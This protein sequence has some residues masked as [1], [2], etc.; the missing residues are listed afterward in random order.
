MR[1]IRFI[2]L[3]VLVGLGL[4]GY[5]FL[6]YYGG[7]GA[8]VGAHAKAVPTGDQEIAYIQAATS[9]ATWE[10]FVAGI[11]NVKHDW[12]G[13]IV[14]DRE[15]LSHG[16]D[17]RAGGG[18]A[19]RRAVRIVCGFA[20]TS[21][22]ATPIT[23]NGCEELGR[24]DPP[25]LA[26]IGG[27]SSDRARDLAE[28]L[29]QQTTWH[30]KPPLLML[31]TATADVLYVGPQHNQ[32]VPL[33]DI[34]P[35]RTF[36]FCFT[37]RPDGRGGARTGLVSSVPAAGRL[38]GSR[39]AGPGHRSAPICGPAWA[40][41]RRRRCR[42]PTVRVLEWEDDP[43]SLDL[44]DQFRT[45][46]KDH[47][48]EADSVVYRLAYSVGDYYLP[49]R[50]ESEELSRIADQ[51]AE[52]GHRRQL[53]VLPAVEKPARRVLRGLSTAIHKE[54]RNLVAVTG[55]SI[56]FNVVYR[57]REIA[58]NIQDMPVPLVFFCHQNP[59]AWP[60]H[61]TPGNGLSTPEPNATDDE[62]LNADIVRV[63]LEAVFGRGL[64]GPP[65]LLADVDALKQ[66]LHDRPNFFDADGNR[67]GGSGEYV[68]CLRPH[69]DRARVL[70]SATL[71]VW[72][73]E[74]RW[75][76]R[77]RAARRVRRGRR[78]WQLLGGLG[79]EVRL[80]AWRRR[81]C[82]WPPC[83]AGS[84]TRCTRA[85]A[86]GRRPTSTT[87]ANGSTSRASSARRCPSW[88]ANIST[89]RT[90]TRPTKSASSSNR[91]AIQR[92]CIRASCRCFP[93]SIAWR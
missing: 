27:G 86:G 55:D 80:R 13:L 25:P 31:M 66:R 16:D 89:I 65:Q 84:A 29:K 67:H 10:R 32:P 7:F 4:A 68:V 46:L 74:G 48:D 42:R 73:R 78:A 34:Y 69:F 64:P 75:R 85:C 9:G 92:A 3:L 76:L 82:S 77:A 17:G 56:S 54:V 62:L 15:R 44:S 23:S 49:N 59:A 30:G 36:R 38:P 26:L 35:D 52:A 24:R 22:P 60:E 63:V 45:V 41:S 2:L 50:P 20:G 37:N 33:M 71:E 14:E 58:W 90:R 40:C 53:L 81:S 19:R 61:G 39:R 43:Y 12:P 5:L 21:S 51:M 79:L 6:R 57:D 83:S 8:P 72:T 87:C 28:A 93:T 88:S 70:P 91:W 11:Q 18:A 47:G 1:R